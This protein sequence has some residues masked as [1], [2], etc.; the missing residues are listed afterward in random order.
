MLAENKYN[1]TPGHRFN[2]SAVEPEAETETE[3][4]VHSMSAHNII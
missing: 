2:G 1:Y 3:T 4:E